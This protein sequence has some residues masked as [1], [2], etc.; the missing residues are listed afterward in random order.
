LYVS[1]RVAKRLLG[2]KLGSG[3]SKGLVMRLQAR[4]HRVVQEWMIGRESACELLVHL[5]QFGIL[6]EQG[7][8]KR[9][10]RG[11]GRIGNDAFHRLQ[12]V[13]NTLD[14]S[15]IDVHIDHHPMLPAKAKVFV[16]RGD[17]IR[18]KS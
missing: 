4:L 16:Y 2:A 9:F 11:Q 14:G 1:E 3:L 15:G 12:K 7:G 17:P 13:F 10:I 5:F 18:H 6:D 8:V